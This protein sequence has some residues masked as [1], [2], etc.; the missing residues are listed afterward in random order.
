MKK[1]NFVIA[2]TLLAIGSLTSCSKETFKE[3]VQITEEEK[4]VITIP[5]TVVNSVATVGFTVNVT[6]SVERQMVINGTG[7]FTGFIDWNDGSPVSNFSASQ[8]IAVKH[9]YA[10]GVYNPV[11]FMT[12]A[13]SGITYLRFT[14]AEV[15]AV[16]GLATL[17]GLK[18]LFLNDNYTLASV[19]VSSNTQLERLILTQ[20]DAITSI[21]VSNNTALTA[22]QLTNCS[23]TSINVSNNTALTY[24]GLSGNN[25]TGVNLTGLNSLQEVTLA[26]NNISSAVSFPYSIKKVDIGSNHLTKAAVDAILVQLNSFGTSNGTV[27]C[28]FNTPA[29]PPTATGL[30]ARA[31]LQSRGWSTLTD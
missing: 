27:Y 14:D 6:N 11:L 18:E 3:P 24:L 15:T 20:N 23:L 17:T 5:P 4:P 29:T 13:A 19:D 1:R 30:A 21:N 25:L 2:A 28:G 16:S 26:F 8:L 9:T 31:A 12:T 10:A 22:L 7:T